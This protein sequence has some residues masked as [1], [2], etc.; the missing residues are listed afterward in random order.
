MIKALIIANILLIVAIIAVLLI[1]RKKIIPR[2]NELEKIKEQIEKD[3]HIIKVPKED[4]EQEL[5]ITSA[6]S[7]KYHKKE[8][9]SAKNI[10]KKIKGTK[11]EFEEKGLEPCEICIK[12]N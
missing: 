2:N 10:K 12:N 8:C 1:K 3:I 6:S 11:S 7:K 5:Y 9:I 4:E